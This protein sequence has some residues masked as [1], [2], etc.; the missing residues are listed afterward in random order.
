M[1]NAGDS[2]GVRTLSGI[3]LCMCL[4]L[5]GCRWAHCKSEKGIDSTS[6]HLKQSSFLIISSFLF[7]LLPY[8]LPYFFLSSLFISL[9]FPLPSLFP[10]IFICSSLFTSFFFIPL[11][12]FPLAPILNWGHLCVRYCDKW[13]LIT[14]VCFYNIKRLTKVLAIAYWSGYK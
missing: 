3:Y 9:L 11:C 2:S 12:L 4:S 6:K 10:A 13:I 14:Y 1:E 5:G 7:L 8:C